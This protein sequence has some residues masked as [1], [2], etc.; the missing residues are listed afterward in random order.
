MRYNSAPSCT[1]FVKVSVKRTP[2][3]NTPVAIRV[4]ADTYEGFTSNKAQFI[5]DLPL[6]NTTIEQIELVVTNLQK[7]ANAE[8]V[9]VKINPAVSKFLNN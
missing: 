7:R 6:E 5:K 8:F 3:A 9:N 2:Y 4:I 1:L